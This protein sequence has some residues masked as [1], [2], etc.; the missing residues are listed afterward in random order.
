MRK[1]DSRTFNAALIKELMK[2]EKPLSQLAAKEW[3]SLK[4]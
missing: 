4:E 3:I 2:E 1:H